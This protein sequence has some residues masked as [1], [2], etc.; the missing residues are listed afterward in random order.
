MRDRAVPGGLQTVAA[1]FDLL[2]CFV[3]DEELG[4]TEV[5]RRLGIAKSS[6]HRMLT[7]LASRGIVEQNEHNAKY[8]LGL[9][10]YELG[11]LALTRV[12]LRRHAQVHLTALR[13][14]IGW[15]VQ[16]SVASGT[17]TLVLERLETVRSLH[18]LPEFHRRLPLHVTAQGK[19]LCAYNP[20]LA[21]ARV[22]AGLPRVTDRS[23]TAATA[24]RRELEA[25]R[26]QGFATSWSEA[27]PHV[28]GI[29]V[30]IMDGR[31][32]A[33]AAISV[34]GNPEDLKP[35]TERIARVTQLAA[36]RISRGLRSDL[37]G[38]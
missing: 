3:E 15:T 16:L 25:V 26:R 5:S 27:V 18:D 10:L 22:D 4:V 34:I 9:R 24:F 30:P 35:S 20:A 12:V 11:T 33:I 17:D 28:G 2:D 1:A 13:E 14:A 37:P 32:V 36:R 21:K 31:G 19:A 29:G 7:S 23:V 6:A 38:A 8:R